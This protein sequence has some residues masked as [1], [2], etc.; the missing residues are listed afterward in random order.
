MC[1]KPAI[2]WVLIVALLLTSFGAAAN[3]SS[4]RYHA[5]KRPATA[6]KKAEKQGPIKQKAKARAV[7]KQKDIAQQAKNEREVHNEEHDKNR[8]A[9]PK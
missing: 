2:G 9:D 1:A 6:V 8:P 3:R 4:S 7:P 5:P